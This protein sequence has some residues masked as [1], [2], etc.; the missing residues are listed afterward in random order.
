MGTSEQK[1]FRLVCVLET[2]RSPPPTPAAASPANTEQRDHKQ[3]HSTGRANGEGM[4]S[5]TLLV[6]HSD[7]I[8]VNDVA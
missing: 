5:N 3:R 1:I 7:A 6:R 2:L 8:E 4:A